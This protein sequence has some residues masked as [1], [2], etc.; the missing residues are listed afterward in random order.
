[1]TPESAG[2]GVGFA[3]TVKAPMDKVRKSFE[4]A[5]GKQLKEC[6]SGDGLNFCGLEIGPKRTV[7]MIGPSTKPEQGTLLGCYYEYVK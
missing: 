3:I 6:E 1:M 5:L 2:M 7:M 4:A